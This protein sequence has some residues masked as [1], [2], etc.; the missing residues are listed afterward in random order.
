MVPGGTVPGAGEDD[1]VDVAE[2]LVRLEENTT[3]TIFIST[4]HEPIA[5]AVYLQN[6]GTTEVDESRRDSGAIEIMALPMKEYSGEG[7]S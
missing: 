5:S 3:F 6:M 1:R 4:R 2:L 7:L